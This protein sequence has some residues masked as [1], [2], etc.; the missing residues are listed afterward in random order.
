MHALSFAVKR[1]HLCA[2]KM[3]MAMAVKFG[4]TPARFDVM[5]ILRMFGGGCDQSE[6][7]KRLG[8]SRQTIWKMV[9]GMEEKGL[10]WRRPD[11]EDKR[12]REV[13]LTKYGLEQ[14]IEASKTFFRTEELRE[15]FD[16]IHDEGRAFVAK[17]AKIIKDVGRGL[18]DWAHHYYS[19]DAPSA[20]M[21]AGA[22]RLN[23]KVRFE[24]DRL[25]VHRP[26]TLLIEIDEQDFIYDPDEIC[27][28][29]EM[30]AWDAAIEKL[31]REASRMFGVASRE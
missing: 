25:E 30:A 16:A 8:V 3:Q 12:R 2:A 13:I 24:V 11:P 20:E 5:F 22:D 9:K 18:R 23:E 14:F 28:E 7:W 26:R 4:L 31:Q 19:V 6:L 10:I 15:R 17:A 21:I 1:A 27:D 29:A